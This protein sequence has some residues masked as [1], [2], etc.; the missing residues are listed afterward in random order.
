MKSAEKP[1]HSNNIIHTLMIRHKNQRNIFW[2]AFYVFKF[3]GCPQKVR[4][5]QQEKIQVI[6]TYFMGLIAKNMETNPL[7]WM[8]NNQSKTETQIINYGNG[9][10]NQFL[11]ALKI[12]RKSKKYIFSGI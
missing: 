6:D 2:N 4:A 9:I 5:S 11:H 10:R 8:K 7:N 12:C 1:N 3:V